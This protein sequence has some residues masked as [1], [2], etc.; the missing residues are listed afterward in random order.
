MPLRLAASFR[1]VV[2]RGLFPRLAVIV[3]VV[4]RCVLVE[5]PTRQVGGYDRLGDFFS[6]EV[7]IERSAADVPERSAP[8]L[9]LTLASG[10]G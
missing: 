9:R 5:K 3:F 8:S 10:P 7:L 2:G 1:F 4:V 6:A